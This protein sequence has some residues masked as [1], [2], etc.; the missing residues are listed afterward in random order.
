MLHSPSTKR[1]QAALQQ[2]ES[3]GAPG[4]ANKQTPRSSKANSLGLPRGSRASCDRHFTKIGPKVLRILALLGGLGSSEVCRPSGSGTWGLLA[5]R[6][7]L[8]WYISQKIQSRVLHVS[9]NCWLL[10]P[11][12]LPG[13]T[14]SRSPLVSWSTGKDTSA[15][16]QKPFFPECS[17]PSSSQTVQNSCVPEFLAGCGGNTAR[18][19]FSQAARAA[20][21]IQRTGRMRWEVGLR[22]SHRDTS[23][24]PE[25][26]SRSCRV[27]WPNSFGKV[28]GYVGRNGFRKR[29]LRKSAAI[30][31]RG[32]HRPRTRE[33]TVECAPSSE[34]Q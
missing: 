1:H 10:D 14:F 11:E 17:K 21:N 15:S 26:A 27:T 34:Q 28:K 13:I 33:T 18:E 23:A 19:R 6:G 25:S 31:I 7:C 5:H 12:W 2:K 22:D 16:I 24:Q 29:Y 30:G 20:S 3:A 8:P 9:R 32:R 4:S